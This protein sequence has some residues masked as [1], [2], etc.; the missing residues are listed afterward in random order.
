MLTTNY[1]VGLGGLPGSF[2]QLGVDVCPQQLLVSGLLLRRCPPRPEIMFVRLNQLV[3]LPE[4]VTSHDACLIKRYEPGTLHQ[5]RNEREGEPIVSV[6]LR[7]FTN[8]HFSATR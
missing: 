7:I 8:P 2:K 6:S 3:S 1:P 5:D 4:R